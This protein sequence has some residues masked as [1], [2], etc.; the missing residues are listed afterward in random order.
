MADDRISLR[1]YLAL[2]NLHPGSRYDLE[3][4]QPDKIFLT[5]RVSCAEDSS[6]QLFRFQTKQ[7]KSVFLVDRG[8]ESR[9]IADKDWDFE[10]ANACDLQNFL[11][12]G[13]PVAIA[14]KKS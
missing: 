12:A 3:E 6:F 14:P 8:A 1:Q 9:L 13:R 11:S 4:L 10:L 2:R 5:E 7:G